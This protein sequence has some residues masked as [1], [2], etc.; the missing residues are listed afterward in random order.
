MR[1]A[2]TGASGFVGSVVVHALR[3]RGHDVLPFGRRPPSA[4]R[5]AMP[6]YQQW[7]IECGAR[8]MDVH[9]VVHCAASV[10]QWGSMEHFRRA[11]VQGTANVLS[12]IPAGARIV[13]VSTASV[14]THPASHGPIHET[15]ATGG[16]RTSQYA[17]SKLA[18]EGLALASARGAVVLR[19]HIVYGPGDSTLWPRVVAARRR[20][21][22]RVPG[23]GRN[24]VSVTHVHN[25]AHAVACALEANV[26]SG[27]YNV[28]D[29]DAP[30]VR[31]LLHWMFLRHELPTRI[32]F[33]P[34]PMAWAGAAAMELYWAA[35]NR[36]GDPPLTRF[37]VA[38]LADE[39]VLDTS[40]ARAALGYLPRWTFR[41]GPL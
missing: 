16:Q 36:S 37:A 25:L 7:D 38:G 35:T 22:I 15:A 27:I 19:P 21:S 26:P 18:G 30:A 14:Y 9:A 5:S 24:R 40:R 31:E 29:D 39:C 8:P 20:G 4:L 2:V 41:D 23:T 11:N 3:D 17:R 13:Y 34:R 6:A 10:G 12:S 33:V 28:A 32:R 1:V